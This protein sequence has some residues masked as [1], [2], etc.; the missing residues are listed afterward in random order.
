MLAEQDGWSPLGG[1]FSLSLGPSEDSPA[2]QV[3]VDASAQSVSAAL[4]AALVRWPV[5]SPTPFFEVSRS[6]PT[7]A[8]QGQRGGAGGGGVE[9]AITF[10]APALYNTLASASLPSLRLASAAQLTGSG[11][12]VSIRG[13]ETV[14]DDA[15]SKVLF[16]FHYIYL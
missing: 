11:A 3:A 5:G 10:T 4:K 2:I 14:I 16:S 9:W 7:A 8:T 6:S 1:S 15:D 13:G 12:G